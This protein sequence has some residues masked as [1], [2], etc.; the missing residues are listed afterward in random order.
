MT[1]GEIKPGMEEKLP[2]TD[3]RLRPDRILVEYGLY[4]QVS[5]LSDLSRLGRK[6]FR[7]G[8]HPT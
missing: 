4:E 8:W 2:C 7:K 5:S 3:S 6:S 1:L